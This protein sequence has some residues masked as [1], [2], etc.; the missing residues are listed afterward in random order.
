MT[1][2]DEYVVCTEKYVLDTEFFY[3]WSKLRQSMELN[4]HWL[5]RKEKKIRAQILVNKIT[6]TAFKGL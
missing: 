2:T 1:F 5:F 4:P 3:K 6:L